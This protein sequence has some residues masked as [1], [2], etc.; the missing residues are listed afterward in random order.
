MTKPHRQTSHKENQV[1][2]HTVFLVENKIGNL[3]DS[4]ADRKRTRALS[5]VAACVRPRLAIG[6]LR[7]RPERQSTRLHELHTI[8]L[9]LGEQQLVGHR[10]SPPFVKGEIYDLKGIAR[11]PLDE[12]AEVID[13]TLPLWLRLELRTRQHCTS[14]SVRELCSDTWAQTS[15]LRLPR[16]GR[17]DKQQ[18][19]VAGLVPIAARSRAENARVQGPGPP[20][21]QLVAEAPP[22]FVP[23]VRKSVGHTRGNVITVEFMDVVAAH[24]RGTDDSLLNQPPQTASDADL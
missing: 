11:P 1:S 10:R 22:Q 23:Q 21:R 16:K 4:C 18:V 7:R 8:P 2:R 9:N 24:Q 3:E 20:S 14:E 19:D 5:E 15:R 6:G 17:V 13:L 12:I